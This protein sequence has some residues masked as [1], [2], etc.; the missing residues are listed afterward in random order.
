MRAASVGN[1]KQFLGKPG[2]LYWPQ[3]LKIRAPRVQWTSNPSEGLKLS[4]L[5][6]APILAGLPN[7]SSTTSRKVLPVPSLLPHVILDSK[8]LPNF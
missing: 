5:A 6:S 1:E 2:W 3:I 7:S 4:E 8:T